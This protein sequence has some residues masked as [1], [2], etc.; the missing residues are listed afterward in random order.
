MLILGLDTSTSAVSAGLVRDG[1]IISEVFLDRGL[2]HNQRLLPL[3]ERVLAE[4]G[5]CPADLDA[6]AVTTGPGS[7][8]GLRIGVMTAKALA[9]GLGIPVVGL[10]T[11]EAIF[12]QAPRLS[13]EG[14][15]VWVLLE[16]RKNQV[17]GGYFPGSVSQ[18]GGNPDQRGG[19]ETGP[20]FGP[21]L[22]RELCPRPGREDPGTGYL[23][24]PVRRIALEIAAFL[25][26]ARETGR[27][28][29]VGPAALSHHAGI[30]GAVGKGAFFLPP[31]LNFPRAGQVAWLGWRGLAGGEGRDPRDI[32]ALYFPRLSPQERP[33]A[34][35]ED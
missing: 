24:E 23:E 17:I 32:Q 13:M 16:G 7:Y 34:A 15:P 35:T 28:L 30:A 26:E 4:A 21:G 10:G 29:F 25:E 5:S 1:R 14:T 27:C 3:V 31:S 8:T 2:K 33:A 11:F 9:Y 6:V 12:S 18:P 22:D 20:G 19:S